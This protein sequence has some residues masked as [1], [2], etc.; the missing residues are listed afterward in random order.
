[1]IKCGH[2]AQ[3]CQLTTLRSGFVFGPAPA[4]SSPTV[5]FFTGFNSKLTGFCPGCNG[6]DMPF[7]PWSLVRAVHDRAVEPAQ[8][9]LASICQK[10]ESTK[11]VPSDFL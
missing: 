4:R 9:L 2:A 10:L 1:M 6:A 7:R 8:L 5:R 11:Q 3:P